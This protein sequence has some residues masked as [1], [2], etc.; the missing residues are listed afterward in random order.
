MA[1]FGGMGMAKAELKTRESEASVEDFLSNIENE[2]RREDA[3]RVLEIFKRVTRE[4]PKMWGPSIVGFGKQDLKYE[5]GRELEWMITGFSPRKANLTLYIMDGFA[6]Y[7]EYLA[8]L[9]KHKTG[10]SCLY[11]KRLSDIDLKVL[12][13]MIT[14]SAKHVKKGSKAN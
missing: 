4:K 5:S 7:D 12:E 13:K 6:K 2:E 10:V 9:G 3:L 11:V 14:E 1:T 8:K